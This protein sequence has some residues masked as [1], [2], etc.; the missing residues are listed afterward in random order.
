MSIHKYCLLTELSKES[1]ET[2]GTSDNESNWSD[3]EKY[4]I[5]SEGYENEEYDDLENY[6]NVTGY[7][8]CR[9]SNPVATDQEIDPEMTDFIVEDDKIWKQWI[10]DNS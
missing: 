1:D 8:I 5:T 7:K 3:E 2:K 10:L 4:G 6:E 9:E